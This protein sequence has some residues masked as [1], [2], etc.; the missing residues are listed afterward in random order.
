MSRGFTLLEVLVA[1]AISA[2]IAISAVQLLKNASDTEIATDSRSDGMASFQRLNLLLARDMQQM[3]NRSVRDEYGD[4]KDALILNNGGDYLF[5][6]TRLGWRNSP[7]TENPRS[8]LQRVAYQTESL[9]TEECEPALKRLALAANVLPD[10][11]DEEGECLIRYYWSVLDRAPDSEPRAQVLIDRL[12]D[13]EIEITT[14]TLADTEDA[15]RIYNTYPEWPTLSP[16]TEGERPAAIRW[17]F[18]LPNYGEITRL[19]LL[20]HDGGLL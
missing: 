17:R 19:W 13:L 20:P 4:T 2:S 12:E 11:Y 16:L 1:V 3:I 5:E 18:I 8:T 10:E 14:L 9:D 7:V 15:Q 6:F